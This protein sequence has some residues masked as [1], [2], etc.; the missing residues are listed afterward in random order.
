MKKKQIQCA[1]GLLVLLLSGCQTTEPDASIPPQPSQNPAPLISTAPT[2]QITTQ[3]T[4]PTQETEPPVTMDPVTTLSCLE[5]QTI[6]QLLSLGDG[7]VLA[8]RNDYVE[9]KGIVNFLDLLDVREDKVLAQAQNDSTREL[10]EQPFQDGHFI[11]RDSADNSFYVYDKTLRITKQFRAGNVDG[12]FSYDRKN[13]YFVDNDVLYRMDV[14]TGNYARMYLQ[15]DLRL[16]SLIGVHPT[17][18]IVAAKCYLSFH[19]DN[20]GVCA[21]DCTTGE[22]LLLNDRV[23]HLWF[24]ED[25]FYAAVPN[26]KIY[27][28][29]IVYGS[30]FGGKLQ[31]ASTS[32]L[33]SDTVSYT[34]LNDSGF[35]IHRTVDQQ[36]LSTTVYDLSNGGVSS[37]LTQY[38]HQTTTLAP[39]YLKQEQLIFGVYPED[40]TFHPVVIDPKVLSYEKSLSLNRENWA[41]LVDQTLFLNY[42][43]EVFGPALPDSL[44]SLRR[45]ADGIE[46]KYRISI[47]IGKQTLGLCGGYSAT[48]E[49]PVAI[50]K[51]LDLLDQALSRY[52]EGFLGQ[53]RNGIGEGGL[54]FC[55]TGRIQGNLDPVGKAAKNR[56]RYE[57]SLDITSQSLDK[58]IHHELWHAIEMRISTDHFNTPQ[59]QALNPKGFLYYGYYSSGYEKLTQW[60]YAQSGSQ[61]CFV[62]AYSRINPREDRAR[63]MEYVMATDASDLLRSNALRNKLEIMS[64]A[65]REHFNTQG[66]QTPYWERFL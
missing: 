56:N 26:N 35:L 46:E 17:R 43:D 11:L 50:G 66:W 12:Y 23:S 58:T 55:L 52:P 7:A 47:L 44:Q 3:P 21:I 20:T 8:C 40:L 4:Q 29:D 10:V 5:W 16:E 19:N 24:H 42:Q 64:S 34:M 25:T 63:L 27:G 62:D 59:W 45:K 39:V 32:S 36:N 18:N 13:Y 33:G 31:K 54:Y 61:C 65:I 14:D 41:T 28:N 37:P 1:L 22:I 6:P 51:A 30:L 57:L 38:N 49:D 53:F 15:Y 48:N 9:G 60:T 2:T